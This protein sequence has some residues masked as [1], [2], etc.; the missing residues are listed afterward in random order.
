MAE[1]P[2]T[3]CNWSDLVKLINTL[4]HTPSPTDGEEELITLISGL[5]EAQGIRHQRIAH[6]PY[7]NVPPLLVG[8]LDAKYILVTHCDRVQENPKPLT[9]CNNSIKTVEGKL[10]NTVSLA[11]CLHLFMCL[12]P[13]NTSLLI[14]TA[15][16][17]RLRP[18]IALAEDLQNTGGRGFISYLGENVQQ[19]KDKYFICVDVRPLDRGGVLKTGETNKYLNLG[20]GLV[21]RTSEVRR[22]LA[23]YADTHILNTIKACAIENHVRLTEFAGAGI[24]ELGR[25]WERVLNETPGFP[26]SDY[27]VAWLQPPITHYHTMHE[28]MAGI[29]ILSL[30]KVIK[31]LIA[32]FEQK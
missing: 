12:K 18:P 23:L 30:C 9:I 20:D 3:C 17:G 7:L 29:D 4:N 25:G 1:D 32:T 22:N 11:V 5:L 28:Q 14:T 10:D 6:Q 19:I 26:Q 27:R 24:T 2:K 31:C 21:L 8:N 13:K 16:E 15:E